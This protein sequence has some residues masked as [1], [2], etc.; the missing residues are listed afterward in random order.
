MR[1]EYDFSKGKRGAVIPSKGKTRITI[2][3]DDEILANFREQAE[4]AGIGYQT[5]INE[6]LKKHLLLPNEQPLTQGDLRRILRE[7]LSDKVGWANGH[8]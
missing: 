7:E 6:A 2:Y 5:L 3:L 8:D 1:K 4:T